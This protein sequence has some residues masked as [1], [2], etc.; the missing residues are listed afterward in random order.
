MDVVAL[1]FLIQYNYIC[2]PNNLYT[3]YC[4]QVLSESLYNQKK[5]KKKEEHTPKDYYCIN[6]LTYSWI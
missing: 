4:I 2:V 1:L 5:K 6:L 3:K